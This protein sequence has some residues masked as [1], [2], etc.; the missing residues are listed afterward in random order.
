MLETSYGKQTNF[1]PLG[2]N[3]DLLEIGQWDFR[4]FG[5]IN[6]HLLTRIWF[7]GF[8]NYQQCHDMKFQPKK[9][10]KSST[11]V[12]KAAPVVDTPKK[13]I[14]SSKPIPMFGDVY[15]LVVAKGSICQRCVFGT[16][17][18][19]WFPA[20]KFPSIF[21]IRFE[22]HCNCQKSLDQNP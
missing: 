13:A 11:Y 14:H 10:Q 16:K 21:G 7:A 17:T 6:Y 19:R 18:S 9:Q 20:V 5:G 4:I 2:Q 15:I 12:M 1:L 3:R 22:T 8:L